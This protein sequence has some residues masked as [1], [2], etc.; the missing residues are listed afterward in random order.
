MAMAGLKMAEQPGE[1]RGMQQLGTAET[2]L[3]AHCRA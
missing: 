1:R 3:T 2:A